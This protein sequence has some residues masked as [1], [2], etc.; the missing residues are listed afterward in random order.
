MSEWLIILAVVVLAVLFLI[1]EAN[2][3]PKFNPVPVV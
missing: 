1:Y 2:K 3:E